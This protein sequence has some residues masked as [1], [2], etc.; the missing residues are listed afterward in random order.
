MTVE[1]RATEAP[2]VEGKPSWYGQYRADQDAA[3]ETAISHYGKIR[4]TSADNALRGARVFY[5]LGQEGM[6]K[7]E[8]R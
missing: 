8:S 2:P 5:Y 7:G 1:Y 6:A 3:W 4:Y